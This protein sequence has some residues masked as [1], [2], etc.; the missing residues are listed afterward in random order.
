[1]LHGYV[2]Y[3]AMEEPG[4]FSMKVQQNFIRDTERPQPKT[5]KFPQ[6]FVV[7]SGNVVHTH[8][9]GSP[10]H[11]LLNYFHMG[12]GPVAL[13]ELPDIDYIPVQYHLLGLY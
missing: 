4:L 8:T 10:F 13:A 3:I 1:M 9:F 11:Q 12:F 6:Q 2:K 5:N 7:V